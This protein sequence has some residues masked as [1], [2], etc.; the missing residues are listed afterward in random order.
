MLKSILSQDLF[1]K[2]LKF[3]TERDIGNNKVYFSLCVKRYQS[4]RKVLE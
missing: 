2:N 1:L 3:L 4:F